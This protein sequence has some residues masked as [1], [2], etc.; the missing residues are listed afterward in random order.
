MKDIK[1]DYTTFEKL[2]FP[3]TIYKYREAENPIHLTVLTKQILYFAPPNSFEDKFDCKIPVRY[4]LLTDEEIY[5]K[6][7]ADLKTLNPNWDSIHLRNE[8]IRYCNMGLLK[9]EK[10]LKLIEEDFWKIFNNRFGVI[11]L[12][13]VNDNLA[14]WEKYSL[15]FNGFCIGFDPKII[16]RNMGGGGPV[17]YVSTLPIIRPFDTAE[18][19][20]LTQSLTK[21]KKWEF[22]KEYRV[23]KFW[24]RNIMNIEREHKIDPSAYTAIIIGDKV[25]S[26][27]KKQLIDLAK[28]LNPQI[29]INSAQQRLKNVL[30]KTLT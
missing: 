12:T 28:A 22:E 20:G 18:E 14:M 4:D 2:R 26:S 21:Q 23:Q 13:A 10:R 27:I 9:N 3:E 25:K 30:I 5:D 8:T 6:Y 16:F 24:Q 1:A 7:Y 17:E 11:S 29:K 19:I 15:N